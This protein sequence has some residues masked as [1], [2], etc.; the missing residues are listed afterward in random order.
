MLFV[1]VAVV[2]ATAGGLHACRCDFGTSVYVCVCAGTLLS[3]ISVA[4]QFRQV[5]M[6][7]TLLQ[8]TANALT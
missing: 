2:V 5:G 1:G 3:A 8:A 6:L 4:T 7:S